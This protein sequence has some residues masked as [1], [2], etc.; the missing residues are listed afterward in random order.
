MGKQ[1]PQG[2]QR[3]AAEERSG[4]PLTPTEA[5]ANQRPPGKPEPRSGTAGGGSAASGE[6]RR[7]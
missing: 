5:R 7:P 3:G 1:K 4:S 6:E 2:E